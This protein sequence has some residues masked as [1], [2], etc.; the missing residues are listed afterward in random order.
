MEGTE[1]GR[2][3]T[4]VASAPSGA[5]ASRSSWVPVI[6]LTVH[7]SMDWAP[8]VQSSTDAASRP[9]QPGK[10]RGPVIA[11]REDFGFSR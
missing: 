8:S 6:R 1:G 11:D 5:L 4:G 10:G 9:S 3:V 7:S 2:V